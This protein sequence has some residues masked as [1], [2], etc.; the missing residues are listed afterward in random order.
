MRAGGLGGLL[1]LFTALFL[2][3]PT[4]VRSSDLPPLN[5]SV[6][7]D[8]YGVVV[9]WE[10]SHEQKF[11]LTVK[12]NN[13]NTT[14]I[15]TRDT[16]YNISKYLLDTAFN[17]YLVEVRT[18]DGKNADSEMFTFNYKMHGDKCNL[19]FPA[20]ELIPGDYQLTVKFRNPFH[21]Y[22]DTPALRKLQT[23]DKLDFY[24]TKTNHSDANQDIRLEYPFTCTQKSDTCEGTVPFPEEQ[25]EYC[26]TVFGFIR[27]TYVQRTEPIC[28]S[29]SLKPRIPI[30]VYIIPV[31]VILGIVLIFLFMMF[32]A[33][34]FNKTIKE[35]FKHNLPYFLEEAS[36]NPPLTILKPGTERVEKNPLVEQVTVTPVIL[37]LLANSSQ[38]WDFGDDPGKTA[39]GGEQEA[40]IVEEAADHE[41]VVLDG[42]MSA[43]YDMPHGLLDRKV[44]FSPG[45][46]VN[47]YKA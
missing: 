21:L 47:T 32:L 16:Q 14:S 6:R 36:Y 5:V 34:K 38:P 29:G 11:T 17:Y 23:T 35:K 45:D 10:S 9:N 3:N 44:E 42:S 22:R 7:C 39:V 28:Y 20:V 19:T 26:V 4:A 46:M 27:Q 25:Q 12:P 33:K 13:G 18:E 41:N 24:I 1:T 30:T 15:K 31:C 40:E 2:R 8:S 37:D 43:G